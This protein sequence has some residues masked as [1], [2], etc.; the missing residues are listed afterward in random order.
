MQSLT[1]SINGVTTVYTTYCPL[2]ATSSESIPTLSSSLAAVSTGT[3]SSGEVLETSSSE[4]PHSSE[5][6]TSNSSTSTTI[7]TSVIIS[8]YT[9]ASSN[10]ISFSNETSSTGSS[11]L[12]Y[13]T[14][15]TSSSSS[16]LQY[17]SA[18]V[19]ASVFEGS[20]NHLAMGRGIIISLL[21][22]AFL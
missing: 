4:I 20:A 2:T 21:A 3:Y 13:E 19:S 18:I 11:R 8:A 1:T 15:G 5:T 6:S 14:E 16:T 7:T 17:T 22:V 10:T 9:S 12:A